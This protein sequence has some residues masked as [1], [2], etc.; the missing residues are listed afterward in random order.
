MHRVSVDKDAVADVN[1][2]AAAAGRS[3]LIPDMFGLLFISSCKKCLRLSQ[4]RM[5]E[6]EWIRGNDVVV[7]VVEATSLYSDTSIALFSAHVVV[8]LVRAHIHIMYCFVRLTFN[9]QRSIQ[10]TKKTILRIMNFLSWIII[11]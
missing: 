4:L 6:E 5:K 3:Q 7:E 1:C 2:S 9:D 8:I 10:Q 11:R